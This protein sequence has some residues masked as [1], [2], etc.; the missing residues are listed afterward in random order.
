MARNRLSQ[1]ESIRLADWMREK[2]TEIENGMTGLQVARFA[3]RELGI[4]ATANSV[5][6]IGLNLGISFKNCQR[7]STQKSRLQIVARSVAH[8]YETLGEEVPEEL[9]DL[10]Q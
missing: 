6:R 10:I 8:L 9:A 5:V 2:Q 4:R 7:T 1:I 3:K